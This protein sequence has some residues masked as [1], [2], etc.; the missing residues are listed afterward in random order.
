[1]A[2]QLPAIVTAIAGLSVTGVTLYD[3]DGIPDQLAERSAPAIFPDPLNAVSNLVVTRQSWGAQSERATDVEYDLTFI[4]CHSPVGAGR[5]QLEKYGDMVAG[6]T[7]F[8][9][10]LLAAD[11]V[12]AGAVELEVANVL[13]FGP[14]ADP[15]GKQFHGCKIVVH[16]T[17]FVN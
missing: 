7:A 6:A 17:E 3:L 16:V 1:M 12:A 4:Y 10:A 14:V 2:L 5:L 15:T 13:E 8:V 9:D 11:L